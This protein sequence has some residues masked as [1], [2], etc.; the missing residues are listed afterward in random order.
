MSINKYNPEGYPD[1]TVYE[2]LNHI[3]RKQKKKRYKPLVFICSP[4]AGDTEY[5]TEQA[6]KYSRFAVQHNYLPIAPHLLFPQFMDD[7]NSEER[8]LGIFMGLILMDKCKEVWVFG[9][10]VSSGMAVEIE[11]AKWRRKSIRYY[12][13]QCEEVG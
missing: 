4:Y 3:E 11:K 6:R 8:N 10:R 7:T 5:N 12:N 13:E 2:A 9:S 1:P